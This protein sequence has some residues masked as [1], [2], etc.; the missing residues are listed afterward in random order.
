[1]TSSPQIF[2]AD[3]VLFDMVCLRSHT[4]QPI[5][6]SRTELLQDGT[7]TDSTPAVEAAWGKFAEEIGKDHQYVLAA[8]HGKRSAESIANFKPHL[9]E[10]EIDD[11]VAK[12]DEYI[13]FYAN[14]YRLHGPGSKPQTPINQTPIEILNGSGTTTPSLTPGSS[15]PFSVSSNDSKCSQLDSGNIHIQEPTLHG[16][17]VPSNDF[18]RESDITDIAKN[19]DLDAWQLE[20]VSVDRA[21]QILPGVRRLIDSI[22]IGRYAVATSAT[23]KFG[24]FTYPY[25]L[26][27]SN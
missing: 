3:A 21:V 24:N 26:M 18:L 25:I 6:C 23:D 5:S 7:L 15:T 2:Y 17:T 8:T 12:I 1:M 20:A 16:E 27:T 14:A 10:H 13:L 22:P 4:R 11:E 9:K 19:K